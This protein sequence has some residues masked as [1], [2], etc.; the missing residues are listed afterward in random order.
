MIGKPIDVREL[1]RDDLSE[2]DNIENINAYV[3]GKIIEYGNQI[4]LIDEGNEKQ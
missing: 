3:R 2:K 1:Y 4:R